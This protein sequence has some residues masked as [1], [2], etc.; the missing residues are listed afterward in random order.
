M[1]GE[2]TES[3]KINLQKGLDEGY[4]FIRSSAKSSHSR[5]R[6]KTVEDCLEEITNACVIMS[7]KYL[8]RH[9]LM[10][11]YIE[12]KQEYRCYVYQKKL[13]YIEEYYDP[14]N[15]DHNIEE[16]HI[17]KKNIEE[18]IGQ[19]TEKLRDIYDDYTVD[20]GIVDGKLTVIEINTPMYLLAGTIMA[21]YEYITDLIHKTERPIFKFKI[22]NEI[23]TIDE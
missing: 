18:Y 14:E 7:Y 10:R 2:L 1:N 3:L 13:R 19:I 17:I 20:L 9:I 4:E 11:K 12:I 15:K 5:K 21:K 8:C 22:Q 6:V 16:Y 23:Y